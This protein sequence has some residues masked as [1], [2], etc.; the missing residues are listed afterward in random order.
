[1]I[2]DSSVRW[3]NVW[4][5]ASISNDVMRTLRQPQMLA[6]E[7]PADVHQFHRIEGALA[8]PRS[9]RGVRTLAF[10]RVFDRDQAVTGP[11]SPAHSHSTTFHC[12]RLVHARR[13]KRARH[14][15]LC[16]APLARRRLYGRLILP[17]LPAIA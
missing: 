3:D 14:T 2:P 11:R 5:V 9:A 10:E 4:L 17:P 15:Y 6:A 8:S 1:V 16:P 12:S 7:I 13:D